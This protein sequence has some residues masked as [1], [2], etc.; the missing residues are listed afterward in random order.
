[1][2]PYGRQDISE[3][4]IAAVIAVL[5]SD[6]LTQG[7]AVVSFE[8]AIATYVNAPHAV[9]VS[10]ATA[11][12]HLTALALD[13]G[14]GDVLWTV[15]NTFVATANAALYCGASVDFVDTDPRTYCLSVE[16]LTA[17]LD[18]ARRSNL[19][20]PKV[21]SPVHFAGQS[22]DMRAIHGLALE[23]GF[24]I[25]EDAS[26]AIGADYLDGKVGDCR[27]S[28][29]CVFSFHPVKI[30]TTGE[31]GAI[32]TRSADLAMRLGEL[33]SHGITRSTERMDKE[34]EG[35]WYYQQI[36]L[37][38]NYRMTDLQAALGESQM[39]RVDDFVARRRI[40]AA[41]YDAAFHGTRL[42]TPWQ[43]P[44]GICTPFMWTPRSAA[45]CSMP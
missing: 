27:Y 23:Y 11:A 25:V 22:C 21:V 1:M 38:L 33:R 29:A 20:L 24:K 36:A 28:D 15:P 30:A 34:T 16:A 4:D 9:A 44:D 2:I 8:R 19:Q 17:K 13:L 12:L 32:T 5:R 35:A 40:L 26:H 31:G 43:S 41:R 14:P 18:H 7:P 45:T 3:D 10:N 39:Q 6:F 37:G 42:T